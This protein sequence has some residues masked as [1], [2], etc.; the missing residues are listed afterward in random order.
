MNEDDYEE[1]DIGSI[2]EYEQPSRCASR[3]VRNK[4]MLGSDKQVANG[5]RVGDR[6]VWDSSPV[7][8]SEDRDML[9]NNDTTTP[10]RRDKR[11]DEGRTG[12]KKKRS[13]ERNGSKRIQEPNEIMSRKERRKGEVEE[14]ESLGHLEGTDEVNSCETEEQPF[15]AKSKQD[16]DSQTSQP[17]AR[18]KELRRRVARK[19]M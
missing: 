18:K 15:G 6:D 19:E 5:E 2:E 3:D 11:G 13:N 4:E 1:E 7:K 17:S 16:L 10:P 8:V 12:N 14:A 9:V